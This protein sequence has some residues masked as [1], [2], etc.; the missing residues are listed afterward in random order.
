MKTLSNYIE[1]R[2][3]ELEE[4]R[5]IPVPKVKE[6]IKRLKEDI[7]VQPEIN[8]FVQ[9]DILNQLIEK[10]FGDFTHSPTNTKLIEDTEPDGN[11]ESALS[12]G[13]NSSGSPKGCGKYMGY[14]HRITQVNKYER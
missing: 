4:D 10:H 14:P 8:S 7:A 12:D 2:H 3:L 1:G 5:V 6:F 13:N 11:D 9:K